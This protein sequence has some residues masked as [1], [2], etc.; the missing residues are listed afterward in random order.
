M[1]VP[2][3]VFVPRLISHGQ[4]HD[5]A[6]LY[7]VHLRAPNGTDQVATKVLVRPAR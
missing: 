5:C 7:S 4:C 2:I 1:L 6:V 3:A